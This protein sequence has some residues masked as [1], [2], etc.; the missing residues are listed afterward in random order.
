MRLAFSSLACPGWSVEKVAGSAAAYGYEGVELRLV[1]GEKFEPTIDASERARVRRAFREAG[2]AIVGLGSSVGIAS[3][4]EDVPG[5][6]RAWL[7]LAHEWES[8]LVR[9]FGRAPGELD[10]ETI[11]RAADAVE[12]AIPTAERLGVAIGLETH[13]SFCRSTD[14]ARVLARVP[15][16]WFG[17]IW[18]THHPHRM[19]EAPNEIWDNLGERLL[20]VHVK[21]ARR[22]GDG[23]D[24][25]LLGEGEVACG[26]IVALLRSHGWGRWLSAEWEKKW[27]P[28]I[29]EPEVAL[30]QQLALMQR[31]VG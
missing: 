18:D 21:D 16:R 13:D 9:V 15:S 27:H 10:D 5:Q 29:A 25:V 4:E 8:P 24:L 28:E 3:D 20:H 17:A 2:Q 23:W 19:G 26:E 30:P 12:A 11:A 14:V 31:W 1:D 22:S 7:E 6:I